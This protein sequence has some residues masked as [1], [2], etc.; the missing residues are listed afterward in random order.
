[1]V[2]GHIVNL[3]GFRNCVNQSVCRILGGGCRYVQGC[4]ASV[5]TRAHVLHEN[6]SNYE[7]E[8]TYS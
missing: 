3:V 4:T 7:S 6:K 2:N 5:V 1:M 8:P